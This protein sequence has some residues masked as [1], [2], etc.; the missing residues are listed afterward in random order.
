MRENIGQP[1]KAASL[2][3]F[4]YLKARVVVGEGQLLAMDDRICQPPIVMID[5]DDQLTDL[6]SVWHRQDPFVVLDT[7]IDDTAGQEPPVNCAYIG[8]RL[9]YPLR[10]NINDR[11]DPDGC[12]R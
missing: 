6:R 12:H 1:D 4:E 8:D 5:G 3:V 11:F 2:P 7:G 10:G 9:P